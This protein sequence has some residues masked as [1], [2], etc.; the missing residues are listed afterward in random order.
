MTAEQVARMLHCS[1]RRVYDLA[2][3]DELPGARHLGRTLIVVR[4]VFE[5]W[6]LTGH[7]APDDA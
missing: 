4:P 5:A 2:Q 3:R 1:R 6:L 7:R